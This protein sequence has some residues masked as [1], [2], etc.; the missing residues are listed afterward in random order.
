MALN[1][2][3]VTLGNPTR[4]S[5]HDQLIDNFID[6][7]GA[8]RTTET[9]EDNADDIVALELKHNLLHLRDEKAQNTEG[10]TFTL[11]AWRTRDLTTVKTNEITG[12]SLASNQITLPA[13][14]YFVDASA[15]AFQVNFHQS[16]IYD[17]TGAADLI[18]GTNS[19]SYTLDLS[20]TRS[21]CKGRFTIAV[22]SVIELQHRCA[23]T[24]VGGF[25]VAGNYTTEV[26]S[27]I[28]IRQVS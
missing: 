16:K 14:T 13:G 26:Y 8:G 5:D 27:E 24:K 28:I 18:I 6:L 21:I 12:A 23:A 20:V 15:P 22:E 7:A 25:G 11:G 4:K 9:V 10:G 3:K 2:T 17:T 19:Y 1:L